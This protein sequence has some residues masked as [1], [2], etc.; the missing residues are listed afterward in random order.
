MD[1]A[2]NHI[3]RIA[4]SSCGE[5]SYSQECHRAKL[6]KVGRFDAAAVTALCGVLT[7]WHRTFEANL[8]AAHSLSS[9]AT[10]Q[11]LR[12]TVALQSCQSSGQMQPKGAC[13]PS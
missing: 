3:T 10:V 11:A 13:R 8:G 1:R 2:T 4:Q 9:P 6:K 5:R 7:M 12:V